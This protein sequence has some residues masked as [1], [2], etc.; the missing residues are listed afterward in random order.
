MKG[1]A[2]PIIFEVISLPVGIDGSPRA[3]SCPCKYQCSGI[4][5]SSV[6]LKTAVQR[7]AEPIGQV[8]QCFMDGEAVKDQHIPRFQFSSRPAIASFGS[9]GDISGCAV[10]WLQA[11]PV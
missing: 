1:K 3:L 10:G 7:D 2:L 11:E 4:D 8:R 6:V 9:G 5:G